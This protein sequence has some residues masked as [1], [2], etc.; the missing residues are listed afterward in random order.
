MKKN[1]RQLV[2]LTKNYAE[3]TRAMHASRSQLVSQ[4]AILSEKS[5]LF[6]SVG[7]N[8]VGEEY[9]KELESI[10]ENSST[11]TRTTLDEIIDSSMDASA[12]SIHSIYTLQQ[13]MGGHVV[14]LERDFRTKVI[15]VAEEW[16]MAVTE[17]VEEES[18]KVRRL[19]ET[20]IHYEKKVNLL[21]QWANELEE[22]G[23]EN[24]PA[25]KEKLERNEGKLKEAFE[26]H[27]I[28]AGRLC[29]LLEEVVVGGWKEL[30][31]LIKNYC[32][33]ESYQADRSRKIYSKLMP[34][35]VKSTK[36]I[37]KESNSTKKKK[38]SK[39]IPPP[40]PLPA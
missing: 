18:K 38:K 19:Q 8:T 28:E 15:E 29:V 4:F 27:E 9:T 33:W 2:S 36:N 6:D 24:P 20:R 13:L 31:N 11:M 26:L 37:H 40:A 21:R 34:A 12:D 3:T 16:E 10:C 35:T 17:K 30:H 7:K 22:K 32:K 14:F 23:K 39:Q 1:L 5:P 25:K